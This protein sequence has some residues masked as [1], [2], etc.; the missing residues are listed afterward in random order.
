MFCI[1]D[2][3][4]DLS[5]YSPQGQLSVLGMFVTS[6]KLLWKIIELFLL[7]FTFTDDTVPSSF[8]YMHTPW[9]LEM[10]NQ[11]ITWQQLYLHDNIIATRYT[12][13][14]RMEKVI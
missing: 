10:P 1:T 4:T 2:Q 3:L 5:A 11:T 6:V 12:S 14:I 8:S 9:L 13:N 7:F